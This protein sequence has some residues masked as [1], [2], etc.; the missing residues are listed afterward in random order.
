MG[1]GRGGKS[2]NENNE[3]DVGETS[4]EGRE[5][6]LRATVAVA[7][8]EDGGRYRNRRKGK[9]NHRERRGCLRRE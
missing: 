3:D 8:V 5:E 7:P 4:W 2:Q 1:E 6:N 9:E